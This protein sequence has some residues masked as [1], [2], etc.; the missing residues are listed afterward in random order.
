MSILVF[1]RRPRGFHYTFRY[2]KERPWRIMNGAEPT[3]LP[4]RQ[5]E[6]T[7]SMP[8]VHRFSFRSRMRSAH[9]RQAWRWNLGGLIVLILL[10]S[11]LFLQFLK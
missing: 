7:P 10:M 3:A 6:D 9:D 2:A 8:S 5:G 4:S 11:L 1:R